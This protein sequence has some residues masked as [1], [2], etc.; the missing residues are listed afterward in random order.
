MNPELEAKR[1]GLEYLDTTSVLPFNDAPFYW[2]N[3]PECNNSTIAIFDLS[4][5]EDKV[6]ES[7]KIFKGE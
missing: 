4:E 7:R 3:D 5:L 1:L 2:F 6:I